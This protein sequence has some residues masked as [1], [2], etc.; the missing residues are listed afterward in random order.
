MEDTQILLMFG[1]RNE[2]AI[3]ETAS[4]YGG[5]CGKIAENILGCTEDTEEILNDTWLAAWNAIPPNCPDC[6]RAFLGRLSRN[7]AL[8]RYRA[9]HTQK[10]CSGLEKMLLELDECIP[11]RETPELMLERRELSELISGWLDS[12]P[13]PER[14]LFVRRY[15]HGV[16][17]KC[18]AREAQITQNTMTQRLLRLRRSLKSRLEQ[19]GVEV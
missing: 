6:L 7:F 14:Q 13:A 4:K 8:S 1:D 12:L 18:L 9:Q 5:Y 19:E 15:W 17:V 16:S 10:R 2:Q 11:A 3:A